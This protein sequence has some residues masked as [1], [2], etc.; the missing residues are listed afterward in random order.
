M[1]TYEGRH[2]RTEAGWV[3]RTD[4][5]YQPR[6]SAGYRTDDLLH[7]LATSLARAS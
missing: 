7:V 4:P 3:D 6:H 2:R 1:S 5:D